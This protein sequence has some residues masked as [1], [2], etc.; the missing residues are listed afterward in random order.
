MQKFKSKYLDR[1]NYR[2]KHKKAILDVRY[3]KLKD[4]EF[5]FEYLATSDNIY[6]VN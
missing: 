5:L 6:Y 4:E 3:P 1:R 2:V